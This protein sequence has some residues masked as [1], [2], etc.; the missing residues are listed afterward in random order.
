MYNFPIALQLYSVGM[1]VYEDFYGTL[2][3]VKEMG[4]DGLVITDALNMNALIDNY[5][6]KEIYIKA[7]E[8]GCDILL[9]PHNSA[10]AV[11]IIKENISEERINESVKRILMFKYENF[12]NYETLDESYLGCDSHKKI[13][14]KIPQ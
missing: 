3:K 12:E 5:S 1:N 13:I 10:R 14:S 2:K 4:Y 6:Y 11:K 9:M 7:I 8:A